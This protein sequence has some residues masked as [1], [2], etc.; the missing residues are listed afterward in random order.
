MKKMKVL[1]GVS[2]SIIMMISCQ[3][4]ILNDSNETNDASSTHKVSLK[5]GQIITID[6]NG[7][8]ATGNGST[9]APYKSLYKA[10]SVATT[11]GTTIHVN[12]G[13]YLETST[14]KLAVGVSIVGEGATSIIRS[15]VTGADYPI[16]YMSSGAEGTNGN[17]SIS[18]VKFDGNNLATGTAIM[19]FARSNVTIHD[20][21]FTNFNYH[22]VRIFGKTG[23]GAGAP[24]IYATGNKFYNNTMTNCA[25]YQAGSGGYGNLSFGGQDGMLIYGN[26]ITQSGR[27][28]GQNGECIKALNNNGYNKGV[29]IYN[30]IL[31]SDA[32]SSSS[33]WDFTIELWNN[34]GGIEIYNNEI[35]NSAIDIAGNVGESK[36]SY[37]YSVSV[38]DNII[39]CKSLPAIQEIGIIIE[40]LVNTSD[41]LIYNNTI[42]NVNTGIAFYPLNGGTYNNIK[43]YYNIFD[44]IGINLTGWNGTF[45]IAFSSNESSPVYHTDNW[46]ILNNVFNACTKSGSYQTSAISLWNKGGSTVTNTYIRNNIFTGWDYASI[47]NASD[48]TMDYLWIQNNNCFN[49][50]NSNN[51]YMPVTP[52]HYTIQN[53]IKTDPLFVSSTNFKLQST[54]KA[55]NA[56]MNV[57]LSK[58]CIGDP[59]VNTPD[60]GAYEN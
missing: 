45:A 8:D 14:C 6:P 52:T 56:G 30:N 3:K 28:Y 32:N 29:K 57:G 16:L 41:V 53:C 42:K 4:E 44:Q 33:A 10:C 23:G 20:C 39:G 9:T 50:G 36:G 13:T 19:M 49:N 25:G 55:I 51:P 7:N 11:S 60:I 12:A 38:H 31:T 59:I 46:Q 34:T 15:T 1:L 21:M 47:R 54:S 58:D 2:V 35:Y 22:G 18:F 43:I 5:A 48:G 24:T 26:T 17:Q 37:S 40:G 27:P